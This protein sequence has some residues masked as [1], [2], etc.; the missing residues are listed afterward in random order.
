[1]PRMLEKEDLLKNV[2]ETKT[3]KCRLC[4]LRSKTPRL[5]GGAFQFRRADAHERAQG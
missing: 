2:V 4:E 3:A 5:R 1:M